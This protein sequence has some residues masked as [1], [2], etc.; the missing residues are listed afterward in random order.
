[1]N[2]TSDFLLGT[3]SASLV[4]DGTHGASGFPYFEKSGMT[5]D[6]TGKGIRVW[7]KVSD[8]T[9]FRSF[10][11][12]LGTNASNAYI[13]NNL[14]FTGATAGSEY[15]KTGEWEAM[16]IPWSAFA[17]TVGTPPARSAITYCRTLMKDLANG[18][19]TIWWGGVAGVNE[20][21]AYPNG[22]VSFTF[23]DT[24]ASQFTIAKPI[25]DAKGYAATLYPVLEPIGS[26]GSLTLAQIQTMQG[27][28]WDIGA[29]SDT[30]AN[31]TLGVTGMTAA[32][33]RTMH[34]AI[35]AYMRTNGLLGQSFA[36]PLNFSDAASERIAGEYWR[37]ARGTKSLIPESLPPTFP[38][39]LRSQN[40]NSGLSANQAFVDKVK[41]S[42]CWGVFTGHDVKASGASGNDILTADFQT[43]VDYCQTQGV[44]VR[45]VSQ[46][47]AATPTP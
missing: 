31:H 24:Y 40:M 22:V 8:V 20:S 43:I 5:I 29:H 45:T 13:A 6:A 12:Y 11:L 28:G 15:F 3:Q 1:M 23:D 21:S 34:E 14:Y 33:Q 35:K 44:A 41:A 42:K 38:R 9:R 37:T 39:R 17:A 18:A 4:T 25:L 47:M 2:D 30:W 46:V 26:G 36:Y 27:S 7:F 16:D 10:D 19:L 32:Q